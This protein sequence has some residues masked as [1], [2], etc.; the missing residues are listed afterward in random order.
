M[1]VNYVKGTIAPSVLAVAHQLYLIKYNQ[2]SS[3]V[4]VE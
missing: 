2:R 3:L 4:F 1:L